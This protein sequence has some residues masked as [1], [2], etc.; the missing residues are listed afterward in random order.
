MKRESDDYQDTRY[1]CDNCGE[2]RYGE[3]YY[4]AMRGWKPMCLCEDCI[5]EMR[6]WNED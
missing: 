2:D 4:I 6:V 1:T 3:Y 5:K